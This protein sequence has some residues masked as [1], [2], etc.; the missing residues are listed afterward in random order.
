MKKVAAIAIGVAALIMVALSCRDD[1]NAT[2]RTARESRALLVGYELTQ[3]TN[4]AKLVGA[5]PQF[6]ADL[7]SVLGSYRYAWRSEIDRSPPR[8][9]WAVVRLVLTNDHGGAFRMRLKDEFPEDGMRLLD[10][11][12][13]TEPAPCSQQPTSLRVSCGFRGSLLA[14]FAGAW[15]PGG[16]G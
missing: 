8:D 2:R 3:A 1:L 10:Y 4:S 16:C 15:L 14:G 7:A 9:P 5:G 6:T 12:R 13:I 11:Q